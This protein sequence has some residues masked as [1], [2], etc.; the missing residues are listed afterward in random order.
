MGLMA[1]LQEE[2]LNKGKNPRELSMAFAQNVMDYKKLHETILG[3]YNDHSLPPKPTPAALKK[4]NKTFRE[5]MEE[6]G[7][8]ALLDLFCVGYGSYGF[9]F[10]VPAL[11]GLWFV[12]PAVM[13]A[14]LANQNGSS[15]TGK[16]KVESIRLV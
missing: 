6:H 2:Q 4:L 3:K 12:S 8:G 9:N 14:Y 16:K 7:L 11:Y 1:R 5:L 13:V 10:D 15:D